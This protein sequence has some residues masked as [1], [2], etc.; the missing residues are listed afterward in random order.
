MASISGTTQGAGARS[1]RYQ[2]LEL[3]RVAHGD[4]ARGGPPA[5]RGVVVAVYG[6][7]L[8]PETLQRDQHFLAQLAR[9]QQV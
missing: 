3:G 6:D 4:G 7:G 1:F 2:R 8:D 5:G 9:A